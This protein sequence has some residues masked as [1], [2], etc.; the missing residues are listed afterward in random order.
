MTSIVDF[1]GFKFFGIKG[2]S[3]E[4]FVEIVEKLNGLMEVDKDIQFENTED[5]ITTIIT[6]RDNANFALQL[7]REGEVLIVEPDWFG[8]EQEEK[9]LFTRIIIEAFSTQLI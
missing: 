6:Y 7:N 5:S 9:D 2:M 8:D 1:E 4:Q 3:V